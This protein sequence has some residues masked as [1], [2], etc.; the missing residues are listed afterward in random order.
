MTNSTPNLYLNSTT[1]R[2]SPIQSPT[3]SYLNFDLNFT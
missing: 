1:I 3:C 2:M